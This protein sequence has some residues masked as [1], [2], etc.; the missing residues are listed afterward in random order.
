MGEARFYRL[1]RAG[2]DRTVRALA[3][4]AAAEGMRAC[5]RGADPARLAWLDDR[6]WIEP[7]DEFLPHGLEGGTH[8]AEQPLLLTRRGAIANGAATLMLLDGAEADPGE[9]AALARVC[10]IFDG[11]DPAAVEA[12]RGLWRR[13]AAAG[14]AAQYWDDASG[15]WTLVASRP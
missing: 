8:D 1:N 13:Y 9:V 14:L 4:R 6:L 3:L 7:E 10:V 12:A 2:I 5:V 15:G 11:R